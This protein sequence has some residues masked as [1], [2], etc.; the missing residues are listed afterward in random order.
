MNEA[1][2]NKKYQDFFPG[3]MAIM[4]LVLFVPVYWFTVIN[5]V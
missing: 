4:A 5:E 1:T 2:K 3:I